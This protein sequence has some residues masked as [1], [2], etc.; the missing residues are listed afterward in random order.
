MSDDMHRRLGATIRALRRKR[1]WTQT[2]LAQRSGIAQANLSALEA[3]RGA[4][5]ATYRK[6]A[7]ALV[8]SLSDLI[9]MAERCR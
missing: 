9:R 1:H 7:A 2:L 8:L 6:I 5:L 4:S 3:G